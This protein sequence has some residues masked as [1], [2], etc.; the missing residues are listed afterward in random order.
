MR[1]SLGD[2]SGP[3]SSYQRIFSTHTIRPNLSTDDGLGLYSGAVTALQPRNSLATI[4]PPAAL[5]INP[6][7][8]PLACSSIFNTTNSNT[9]T[10][11]IVLWELGDP[12]QPNSRNPNSV[13][14]DE[15]GCGLWR[16]M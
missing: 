9:C 16:R 11:D 1:A 3:P 5:G 2:S 6:F 8:A 10:Q 7:A 12:G 13:S 15:I 14:Q 4:M